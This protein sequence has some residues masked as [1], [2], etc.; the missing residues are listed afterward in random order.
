MFVI[1]EINLSLVVVSQD[2]NPSAWEAEA[3]RSGARL[4]W[5]EFLDSQSLHGETLSQKNK[6][7]KK[8]GLLDRLQ[9]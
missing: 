5:G 7:E 6:E 1:K 8:R 2:T 3:G 4:V 9:G